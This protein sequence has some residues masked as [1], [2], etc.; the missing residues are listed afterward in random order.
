MISAALII[1]D[2]EPHT[3]ACLQSIVGIVDEVAVVDTGS[4]DSSRQ[5]GAAYG[6]HG[7]DR[8]WDDNFAA[9]RNYSIDQ[10]T[11][12]WI[13]SIDADERAG[14]Y[15]RRLLE[16]ELGDPSRCACTVCFCPRTLCTPYPEHRLFR[17][18]PRIRF[19]SV[20]SRTILP[21]LQRIIAAGQERIGSSQLTIDQLGCAG[22]SA[23][24]GLVLQQCWGPSLCPPSR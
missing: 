6:G 13:L 7:V 10:V 18:D 15:D 5:I 19:Q 23:E 16:T 24:L 12:E 22:I 20:I 2:E 3:G 14:A 4:C 9:T 21:D 17:H 11:G 8:Q 1:R